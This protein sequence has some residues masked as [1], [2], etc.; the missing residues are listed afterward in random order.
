VPEPLIA[1]AAPRW[2]WYDENGLPNVQ[3]VMDQHKF[4]TEA[5]KLANGRVSPEMMFDLGPARE[6]AERLKTANPFT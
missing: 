5:M 3:S 2:T 6:A 1:A 4:F